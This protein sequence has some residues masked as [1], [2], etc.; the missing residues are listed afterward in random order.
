MVDLSSDSNCLRHN[1]PPLL[2][3]IV[4]I[5]PSETHLADGTES[6]VTSETVDKEH[7]EL[8]ELFY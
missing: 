8:S 4:Q 5:S 7:V 3:A 2:S 6:R 1:D